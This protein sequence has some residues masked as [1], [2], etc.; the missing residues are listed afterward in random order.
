MALTTNKQ[1]MLAG[2]QY[3]AFTPELIV[4]RQRCKAAVARFNNSGALSRR[5]VV[6]LW[7][8]YVPALSYP[9]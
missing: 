4:E 1:K 5:Q 9:P 8:A 7:R 3:V 6:E 2:E